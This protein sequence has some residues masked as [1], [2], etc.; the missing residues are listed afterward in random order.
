MPRGRTLTRTPA[1]R[2]LSARNLASVARAGWNTGK[3]IAKVVRKTRKDK[4]VKRGAYRMHQKAIEADGGVSYSA[5]KVN[6]KIPKGIAAGIKK[7]AWNTQRMVDGLAFTGLVG[8]TNVFE[9]YTLENVAFQDMVTKL[10]SQQPATYDPAG[11][12]STANTIQPFVSYVNDTF[13]FSNLEQLTTTMQ[14]YEC[15]AIKD[16]YTSA[17][18]AWYAEGALQ[19]ENAPSN[20]L[21]NN[22]AIVQGASTFIVGS[23]PFQSKQ[24]REY[25]KVQKVTNI[26]LRPGE[27]HKHYVKNHCNVS[28]ESDRINTNNKYYAGIT[29]AT[30]VAVTGLPIRSAATPSQVTTGAVDIGLV[31]ERHYKYCQFAPASSTIVTYNNVSSTMT[32]GRAVNIDSG[33]VQPDTGA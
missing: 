20:N 22:T 33:A 18:A 25:W 23:T 4:G 16:S 12:S 28:I 1:T 13:V 15:I 31:F 27:T 26:A 10:Y 24:F 3:A 32:D 14:I 8:R 29:R 11:S 5:F 6:R 9:L 2:S 21:G 19:G 30:L 7:Q 17:A